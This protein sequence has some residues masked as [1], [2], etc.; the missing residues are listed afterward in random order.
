MKYYSLIKSD[1]VM[2]DT[3]KKKVDWLENAAFSKVDDQ[4]KISEKNIQDLKPKF[5]KEI[6]MNGRIIRITLS[7][8]ACL[9]LETL[10]NTT[11]ITISSTC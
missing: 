9:L 7:T 4:W 1:F 2:A 10:F 11:F 3:I 8:L 6:A 5:T